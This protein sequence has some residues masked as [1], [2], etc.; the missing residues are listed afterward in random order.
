MI[1][2]DRLSE[3]SPIWNEVAFV[4]RMR[5]KRNSS[6]LVSTH[7]INW[8]DTRTHAL[9]ISST[10]YGSVLACTTRL[11]WWKVVFLKLSKEGTITF[12]LRRIVWSASGIWEPALK[13]S[14]E[15]PKLDCLSIL[16]SDRKKAKGLGQDILPQSPSSH[17]HTLTLG[18]FRGVTTRLFR[19]RKIL[20]TV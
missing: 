16:A 7:L 10:I 3:G 14:T 8:I 9:W 2:S 17:V 6:K 12:S 4:S 5:L 20:R 15:Q 19:E 11:K 13:P 1:L 18:F